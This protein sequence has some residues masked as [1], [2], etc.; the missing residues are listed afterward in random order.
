MELELSRELSPDSNFYFV[1]PLLFLSVRS[2]LLLR[3]VIHAH[4]DLQ[5]RSKRR[6]NRVCVGGER[7]VHPERESNVTERYCC[8]AG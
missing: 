8:D 4:L 5:I 6:A 2:C 1:H 7:G 3:H